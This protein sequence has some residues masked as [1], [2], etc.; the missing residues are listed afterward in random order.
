MS[1][2]DPAVTSPPRGARSIGPTTPATRPT[3]MSSILARKIAQ[4]SVNIP[5]LP[6]VVARINQLLESE[7]SGAKEIGAAIAMDPPMASK[8]LRIANSV[9]YGLRERVISLEHAS[10]VLGVRV[11]RNIVLQASVIDAFDS[12]T[13]NSNFDVEALWRHSILTGQVAQILSVQARAKLGLQPEEF[14]TCGLLHDLGK[15]V[16]LDAMPEN[17]LLATQYAEMK[18]LPVHVTEQEVLGFDHA[19][20]GAKIAMRWGFPEGVI[21]A[22]QYHHGPEDEMESDP[23]VRLVDLANR[24]CAR[25]IEE[26]LDAAH[27]VLDERAANQLGLDPSAWPGVV[28]QAIERLPQI[29]I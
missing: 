8:V 3:P 1:Q 5:T 10:A 4:G 17:Y 11:L 22:I 24:V 19:A 18:K 6:T 29:E 7:Q 25:V 13:D 12:L 23:A 15:V 21:N 14:Y 27:E 2:P 28:E 20:V 16:M 9:H 26:N